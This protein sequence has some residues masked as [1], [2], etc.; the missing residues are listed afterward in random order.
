M[1]GEFRS[2]ERWAANFGLRWSTRS[3]ALDYRPVGCPLTQ[4]RPWN[5]KG[6]SIVGVIRSS[7]PGTS[8]GNT[9]S[10]LGLAVQERA[11]LSCFAAAGRG[12]S[13]S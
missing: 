9:G 4:G 12:L 7:G 13:G 3:V 11:C 1:P 5:P 6:V 10:R 2:V 8:A